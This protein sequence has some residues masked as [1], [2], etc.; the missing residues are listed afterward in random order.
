MI[1]LG[2]L[3]AFFVGLVLGLLGGGGS[4]L[5]VPVFVYFFGIAASLATAYSLFVVGISS[6][7][8]TYSYFRQSLV[9]FRVGPFF[10][11]PSLIGVWV[12]R[13]LILPSLPPIVS[14]MGF[15]IGKDRLI[16]LVFSAVMGLA[17]YSMLRGRRTVEEALPSAPKPV[18]VP[19]YGLMAGVLMGFVGAGGGFL[20]IPILVGLGKIE[21]KRAIGTSLFIIAA[22]S[23]F[24]FAVDLLAGI[25]LDWA[26]LAGF[27]A[28]SI[29]G[30]FVGAGLSSRVPSH[31]LKRAFGFLVLTI[32]L[33]IVTR[34][35][36]FGG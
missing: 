30:I 4:I 13:R 1:I 22:S 10:L 17:S 14:G 28:L 16:L 23:L 33:A 9:D 27:S 34:E 26:F 29:V 8:G 3:G 7:V 15:S 5:C 11:I 24:G 35:L 25:A 32:A 18:S 31:A 12:S 6:L 21:M 36:F 19:L 2:Y 20:I